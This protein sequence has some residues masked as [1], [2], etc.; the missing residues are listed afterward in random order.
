MADAGGDDEQ[1][2]D[3]QQA[4]VGKSSDA[5]LDG[6]DLRRH[7]QREGG[8]HDHIGADP[9]GYEGDEHEEQ[10]QAHVHDLPHLDGL[11]WGDSGG[12]CRRS[13]NSSIGSVRHDN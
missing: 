10:D 11:P 12:W 9:V 8:Q 4:L 13:G 5:L 1:G 7:A 3:R 6:D 2:E